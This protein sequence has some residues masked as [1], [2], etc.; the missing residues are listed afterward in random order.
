[1]LRYAL[2]RLAAGATGG[3]SSAAFTG[4]DG[5]AYDKLKSDQ[6]RLHRHH[7]SG[8][9]EGGKS[10]SSS[11]S[12]PGSSTQRGDAAGGSAGA[13]RGGFSSSSFTSSAAFPGG[14]GRGASDTAALE[15]P[16]IETYEA[17]TDEQLVET[18]RL[19][20][21]QVAQLRV[22]YENFH[23]EAD[24][25]FRKMIFDYHDKT[26]Q[27]SQ[28][29]G[30]MQQASLQINREALAR[31]RDE[32][33]RMTRDKRL[34]FTLCTIWSLIFWV[35][36]RR[37]YVMK[38]E[39]ER[40]PQSAADR[41]EMNPSVTGAGSYGNNIFTSSRRSGRMAETSW[42][43]EV[44]ERREA[45]DAAARQLSLLQHQT[46]VAKAVASRDAAAAAPKTA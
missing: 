33:D 1:M 46:E 6:D 12:S 22:I 16:T 37:H 8:G 29:H 35:W 7:Q 26:M 40:E 11:S 4:E 14:T 27:L 21:E 17:M 15:R 9:A 38:R 10:S 25:H 20:G 3:F 45:Q 2:R 23:Y 44:R 42:E 32:Q 28:V 19:R 5:G 41:G 34:V 36:V 13:A 39:L 43:R 18:L 30:K 24:R 31:M